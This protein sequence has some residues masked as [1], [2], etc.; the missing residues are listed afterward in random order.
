MTFHYPTHQPF[1]AANGRH[2]AAAQ[3]AS[4][5]SAYAA[6]AAYMG[7]ANCTHETAS[8]PPL[9]NAGIRAGEIIGYRAWYLR[10]GLLYGMFISNYAWKPQAIE[11]CPKVDRNWGAG[12][13]AFKTLEKA[14]REYEAFAGIGETVV[15]GEV[16][17]W[18]EVIEH[19]RGY[20][21]E[22]AAVRKLLCMYRSYRKVRYRPWMFWKSPELKA[23]NAR[24][25]ITGPVGGGKET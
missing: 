15:F 14:K 7:A 25:L 18:G 17:L 11:R 13:H 12:L 6:S 1:G 10:D 3:A 2:R 21:A 19:E 16:A 8:E 5:Y 23:L 9:E 22:F 24:Y 20:R 4:S